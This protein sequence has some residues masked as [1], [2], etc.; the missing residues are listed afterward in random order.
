MFIR[1][2]ALVLLLIWLGL[3]IY[4]TA[5]AQE[6]IPLRVDLGGYA[7][8]NKIPFVIAYEEGIYEKNGLDV[9]QF[10][11]SGA[12]EVTRVVRELWFNLFKSSLNIP[13]HPIRPPNDRAPISIGGGLPHTLR[14]TT[15]ANWRDWIVLATTDHIVRWHIVAQP[16]ITS[17]EQL[18]GKRLGF[19]NVGAMTHYIALILAETMGW[20]PVQDISLISGAQSYQMLENGIVD[21]FIAFEVP[22]ADAVA[23]GYKSLFDTRVLD[24][25][26]AGSGVNASESWLRDNR[27]SARLFIKSLVEAVALMKKDKDVA[28]RAMAKWYNITDPQKQELI[29][30]G[31]VEMPSKPYPSVEGIKKMMEVYDSNEMRKHKP[32]DFYD[33]SFVRELDESGFVDSLYGWETSQKQQQPNR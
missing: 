12:T 32:E 18:K 1:F 20:D 23:A 14:R 17:L 30:A 4:T 25:P 29:Y 8:I 9:D 7:S 27:E 19:S 26:V 16:D 21:A 13:H 3:G 24:I 5:E 22:Y 33:D 15:N 28:F 11:S 31:A 6:R 10:V 2:H